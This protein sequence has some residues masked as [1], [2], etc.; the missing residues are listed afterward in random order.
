[1]YACMYV[2]MYPS[3]LR[4]D[5]RGQQADLRVGFSKH[6]TLHFVFLRMHQMSGKILQAGGLVVQ[7]DFKN[8]L[9]KACFETVSIQISI[10]VSF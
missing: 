2:C 5:R 8:T 6:S 9:M 3:G 10:L 1:M 4:P 7:A